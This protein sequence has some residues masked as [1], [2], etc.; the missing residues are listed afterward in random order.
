MLVIGTLKCSLQFALHAAGIPRR[1]HRCLVNVQVLGLLLRC[2]MDGY[3]DAQSQSATIDGDLI[4]GFMEP[5][6]MTYKFKPGIGAAAACAGRFH[7][8]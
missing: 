7:L 8:R 5:M 3:V 2:V 1:H 6:V 4:Q